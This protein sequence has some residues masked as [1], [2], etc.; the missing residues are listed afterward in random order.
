MSYDE[1]S[2]RVHEVEKFFPIYDQP[3][4]R[5]MQMLSPKVEKHRWFRKFQALRK[6]SFEVKKGETFGIVGRNGSGKSTLLQLICGTL[7]P[8][9]GTIA[10]QGRIAALLELGAGF[11]SEFTG[12]ENVYLNGS[13]LGLSKDEIDSRFDEIAAFADIGE[14]IDQ[15]VRTYSS[16]MYVRLAFAVAINVQPD[17]LVIDEA[18]SVGDEAFQRRCY[19]RIQALRDSGATIIFVSHSASVVLELCDRAILLDGGQ[20]LSMGAPRHVVSRYH[21]LLYASETSRPVVR[22][23]LLQELVAGTHSAAAKTD[24]D[25]SAT[26]S[27]VEDSDL[28]A[29]PIRDLPSAY[30]DPA[31]ISISQIDYESAGARISD[32]RLCTLEG[33]KVNVLR[34]GD[35]YLYRYEVAFQSTASAVRFGMMV[36][37]V[38]GLELGGGVSAQAGSGFMRVE[39]ESRVEVAFRFRC[40]LASGVYFMNAGVVAAD[41]SGEERYLHRLVD[42]IPFRVML[43]PDRLATGMVDFS[44]KARMEIASHPGDREQ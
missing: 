5:L 10:V 9:A 12:R 26:S 29:R 22:T 2:V 15:P 23:A 38:G 18:L 32:V 34:P 6:L 16:G 36:K 11:N 1:I 17:I 41:D 44:P 40:L 33:E 7:T 28:D 42:A 8:N 37:T 14:F 19:A 30:F 4:Y 25:R 39:S 35:E 27:G 20:M 24:E 31:L 43:D 13:I 21:K 3:H